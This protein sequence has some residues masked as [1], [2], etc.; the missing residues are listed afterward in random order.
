MYVLIDSLYWFC[1][2]LSFCTH[3]YTALWVCT[4]NLS[5]LQIKLVCCI[6]LKSHTCVKANPVAQPYIIIGEVV[7][8]DG[9]ETELSAERIDLEGKYLCA[10]T[11]SQ[12]LVK[13]SCLICTE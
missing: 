9:T 5:T 1:I 11:K 8:S 12:P 10:S 6:F 4:D 2:L 3:N 7:T 13:H